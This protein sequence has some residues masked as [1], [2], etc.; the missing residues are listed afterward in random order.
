[1]C[2]LLR[3]TRQVSE[4]GTQRL[5][6]H[7]FGTGGVRECCALPRFALQRVLR[8]RPMRIRFGEGPL[9]DDLI[10]FLRRSECVAE[11]VGKHGLEVNPRLALAPEMARLEI[12]GL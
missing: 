7:G 12:E 10:E 11:R 8:G 5:W 2:R 9:V 6:L 4:V 3:R 1:M